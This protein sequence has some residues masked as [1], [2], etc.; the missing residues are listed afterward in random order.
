MVRKRES[1]R[2]GWRGRDRERVR[3]GKRDSGGKDIEA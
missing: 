2:D 3:E 1:D